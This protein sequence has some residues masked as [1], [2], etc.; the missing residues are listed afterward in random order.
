LGRAA[1]DENDDSDV[2]EEEITY[3]RRKRTKSDRFPENLTREVQT[4]DVPEAERKCSCCGEEM[5]IID[6]DVRERLEYIPAKMVV[7]E[8]H[9]PKRA[10]GKCKT[11]VTVASPPTPDQNG[12][13]AGRLTAWQ[14]ADGAGL[15]GPRRKNQGPPRQTKKASPPIVLPNANRSGR[16]CLS[17]LRSGP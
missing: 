15:V 11:G 3:R 12:S 16:C 6:T 5:P 14:D 7:H 8:L 13:T 2:V 17:I 9:N 1:Q 4:I 10:C